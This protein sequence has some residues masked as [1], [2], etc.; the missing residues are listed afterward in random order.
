MIIE[1]PNPPAGGAGDLLTNNKHMKQVNPYINFNGNTEEAFNFY[2]TIF[3]GEFVGV[4]RFKDMENNM[5]VTGDDLNKIANIGLPIG[6][7]TLL[8]GD[9][10]P[11]VF[12]HSFPESNNFS[13]CLD[14][15]SIEETEHLFQSLSEGGKENMPLQQTEWAEKFGMCTDKFGV[16]WMLNYAGD[17]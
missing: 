4:V 15:E 10:G 9:D 1:S 11:A 14:T 16:K 5:G 3:G 8:M 7:N 13:I 17:K 6:E 12:G 2:K